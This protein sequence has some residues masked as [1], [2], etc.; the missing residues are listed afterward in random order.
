MPPLTWETDITRNEHNRRFGRYPSD[1]T[2]EEWAVAGPLVPPPRPGG[3]QWRMLP[4][5]FPPVST[6]HGYFYQWCND[7][8]LALL[9]V[10]L[11]QMA[12]ELEGKEPC[13][14]AGII[15]SH[16]VKTT[17]SGGVSGCYAG[18]KVKG[19]KRHIVTD[20]NGFMVGLVVPSAAI[21]HRD[22]AVPTLQSIRRFYP[23]L[24]HVF[25]EGGYAGEKLKRTLAGKGGWTVEVIRRS[26][27]IK[28]FKVLP[29]RWVVERTFAWLG[30]CRRLA[31]DWE[32]SIESSTAWTLI[33]HI[34]I[35][36]RRLARHCYIDRLLNQTLR[37]ALSGGEPSAVRGSARLPAPNIGR[38]K[39]IMA[40]HPH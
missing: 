10:A 17:E 26:D 39:R 24:R 25:A 40:C 32:T 12:R 36:M 31:K 15:D 6:V 34:R 11:V 4:K 5:D 2:D 28:G 33:A 7:G 14:S 23:F 35:L 3:V 38:P 8:T 29:R 19:R 16:S 30:R 22:G 1:L 20:T 21:Q 9:N 18:K 27:T 37:T 13:P